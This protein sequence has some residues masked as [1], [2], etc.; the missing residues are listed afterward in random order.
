MCRLIFINETDEIIS[1]E[2][3]REI[4]T[5]KH[6]GPTEASNSSPLSGMLSSSWGVINM[7]FLSSNKET[8][9]SEML[10]LHSDV[11]DWE[12]IE[13]IVEHDPDIPPELAVDSRDPFVPPKRRPDV[14]NEAQTLQHIVLN[15]S[16]PV[17]KN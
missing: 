5:F 16:Y 8:S 1:L 6:F 14:S 17:R 4:S 13:D 15:L 10:A 11:W 12:N 7:L 2:D 9:L 3:L